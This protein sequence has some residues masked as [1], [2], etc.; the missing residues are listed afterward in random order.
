[1]SY[2]SDRLKELEMPTRKEVEHVLLRTLFWHGGVIKEFGAGQETVGKMA[3]E[4]Q[5]SQ[6]QRSA[7][8]E[9]IYRRQNRPKKA[10]LWHRLLFRAADSLAQEKMVSR[11]SQTVLLTNKREWM[12]TEKGFDEAL[13]LCNMPVYLKESLPIKSYEVQK[14][15][16]KLTESPKPDNYD[17]VDRNKKIAKLSREAALRDRGFR[18]AV[19]EAYDCKCAICGLKIKSPDS[20]SWEVEAAHIVPNRSLGRDDVWNGIALCRLHHWALDVGW[21]TLRDNYEIEVSQKIRCL[22][23]DFGKMADY[24]FIRSLAGAGTKPHLP[25]HS[26]IYPHR[27]AILWHRENVFCRQRLTR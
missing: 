3:D 6:L 7:F 25:K 22:P 8:L 21:F 19:V 2:E 24:E 15:V 11:P 1:M 27:N 12:L 26:E 16:H 10:F 9:T 14:I 17:P 13:K 23:K 18:Q 4:F 20:L 5:L